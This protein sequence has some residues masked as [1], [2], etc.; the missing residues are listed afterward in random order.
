MKRIITSDI[1]QW[2]KF[3]KISHGTSQYILRPEKIP[4]VLNAGLRR[5]SECHLR[6]KS[7][8]LNLKRPIFFLVCYMCFAESVFILASE[9]VS[10]I[11]G[12]KSICLVRLYWYR[13]SHQNYARTPHTHSMVSPSTMTSSANVVEWIKLWKLSACAWE[14]DKLKL[15]W[16]GEFWGKRIWERN[17]VGHL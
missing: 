8:L 2:I 13:P 12:K 4:S 17:I 16:I 7:Q 15:L 14:D 9:V 3:N 5:F 11:I 6:G 1:S 10:F